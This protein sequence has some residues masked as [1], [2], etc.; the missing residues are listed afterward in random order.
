M[1]SIS[2]TKPYRSPALLALARGKPCLLTA[3]HNCLG[4]DGS[5]TVACHSNQSKH[6]KGMARKA[7]DN[8]SVWGCINCHSWLDQGPAPKAEK[9]RAFDAAHRRQIVAWQGI[10]QGDAA[11]YSSPLD[12]D[13]AKLA[14]ERLEQ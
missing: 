10:Y 14:L 11:Y 13:A 9:V 2:K 12:C 6:G 4:R 5:T 3:V 7:D 8:Y 1:T